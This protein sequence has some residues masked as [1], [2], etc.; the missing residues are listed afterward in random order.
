MR[1]TRIIPRFPLS[2]MNY[3]HIFRI[4]F[5]PNTLLSI[6][7]RKCENLDQFFLLF[8]LLIQVLIVLSS[9][10]SLSEKCIVLG[11]EVIVKMC[12]DLS[13]L[14]SHSC[15]NEPHVTMS[16]ITQN[17]TSFVF[18]FSSIQWKYL[19][20]SVITFWNWILKNYFLCL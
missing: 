5:T 19:S 9:R 6:W 7:C 3:W 13:K 12:G 11:H 17:V 16:H 18:H 8:L 20:V 14:S 15:V 10:A 2:A 4:S 1:F